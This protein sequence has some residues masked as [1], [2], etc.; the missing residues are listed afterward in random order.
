MGFK[1]LGGCWHGV[2]LIPTLSR[3]RWEEDLYELEVSQDYMVRPCLQRG[4]DWGDGSVGKVLTVQ[5]WQSGF[6]SVEPT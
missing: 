6:K 2:T 1:N 5:A 3:Q 4:W